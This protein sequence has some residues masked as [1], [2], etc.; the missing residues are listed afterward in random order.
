M[1]ATDIVRSPAIRRDRRLDTLKG[2]AITMVVLLHTGPIRF[3]APG[4]GVAGPGR[5]LIGTPLAFALGLTYRTVL[6]LAVP[7]FLLVSLSLYVVRSKGRPKYFTQRLVRL[8][9]LLG[10]W[11]V[12]QYTLFVVVQHRMP[13]LDL[14][15]L[16]L[17]GPPLVGYGS[18][19]VLYFLVDLIALVAVCE[20][21]VVIAQRA[22]A[23]AERIV[24][25]ALIALP[26]AWFLACPFIG[27][28]VEY[29]A[30]VSFL[31]YCGVVLLL[32]GDLD[33]LV[34][35]GWWFAAGF[36]AFSVLDVWEVLNLHGWSLETLADYGRVSVVL[37]ALALSA[38]ILA[39]VPPSKPLVLLGEYSL[40][41]F[42]L[43][44][45]F[46]L[47]VQQFVPYHE[48]VTS[49]GTIRI[50]AERTVF[51]LVLTLATVWVLAKTPLRRFVR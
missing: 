43:H 34:P 51:T 5:G 30:L 3:V 19:T 11:L 16:R 7:M 1:A 18:G 4:H 50:A 33:L 47:L 14:K 32:N 24:A 13:P 36:V 29:W 40:G 35:K 27:Q 17:G 22:G 48:F 21:A 28:R 26:L 45:I 44:P 9:E 37:G 49:L 42:V 23:T 6:E 20:L 41:I 25:I 2:I 38:F 8:I 46:H 10:F 15:T 31:P 12:V 39:V